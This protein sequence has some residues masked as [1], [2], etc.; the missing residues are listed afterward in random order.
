MCRS[1]IF[2]NQIWIILRPIVTGYTDYLWGVD[3]ANMY[4]EL[5]D[6]NLIEVCGMYYAKNV[7]NFFFSLESIW[8]ALF[9][10]QK[11]C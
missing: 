5:S 2:K 1:V 9:L 3:E 8:K 4:K 11:D 6:I 7:S 10:K